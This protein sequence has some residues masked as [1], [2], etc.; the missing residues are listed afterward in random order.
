MNPV[1]AQRRIFSYILC[2][3]KYEFP[4]PPLH[5]PPLRVEHRVLT[6]HNPG[7]CVAPQRL[8]IMTQVY[9]RA[10]NTSAP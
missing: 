3:I 10:H 9:G 1:I 4:A 6:R 7:I 5:N 2:Y 8:G